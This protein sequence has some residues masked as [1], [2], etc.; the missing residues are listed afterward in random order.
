MSSMYWRSAQP[1]WSAEKAF[2]SDAKVVPKIVEEFLKN[3]GNEVQVNC[4]F[5]PLL[6]LSHWK[7]EMG[8]LCGVRG[9]Q[10]CILKVQAVKELSHTFFQSMFRFEIVGLIAQRS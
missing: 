3:C 7:A 10:K 6:D 1:C 8:W 4:P 5:S 9:V 2:L